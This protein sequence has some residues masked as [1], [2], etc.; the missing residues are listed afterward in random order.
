M[1]MLSI[2]F[3]LHTSQQ[4]I[5]TTEGNNAVLLA[6]INYPRTLINFSTPTRTSAARKWGEKGEIM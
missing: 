5:E 6:L 4:I 2:G 1:A 3:R